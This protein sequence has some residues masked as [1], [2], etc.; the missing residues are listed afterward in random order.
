MACVISAIAIGTFGHLRT[1]PFSKVGRHAVLFP[2][3][4]G[5]KSGEAQPSSSNVMAESAFQG[6]RDGR[7]CRLGST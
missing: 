1:E 3:C 6:Q 5:A 2:C 4:L 7:R